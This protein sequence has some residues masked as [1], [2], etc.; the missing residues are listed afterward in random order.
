MA[1]T[2]GYSFGTFERVTPLKLHQ[3]VDNAVLTQIVVDG[4]YGILAA[5][6]A[7]LLVGKLYHGRENLGSES[8]TYS[9]VCTVSKLFIHDPLFDGS[10]VLASPD[11]METARFVSG[12]DFGAGGKVA[13]SICMLESTNS[14]AT[15]ELGDQAG[16]AL[17]GPNAVL[18]CVG[19]VTLAQNK[20]GRVIIKGQCPP[21]TNGTGGNSSPWPCRM[22]HGTIGTSTWAQTTN[23]VGII[24][25]DVDGCFLTRLDNRSM[26]LDSRTIG[27][28]H[29][30]P[31]QV[32][33]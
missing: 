18:G 12:A 10:V 33:N 26:P 24:G 22:Y 28:Y 21:E 30:G 7:S 13:G 1:I 5:T 31:I 19:A 2:R 23:L 4:A 15:I 14:A 6:P 3:L 8:S 17:N 9:G 32:A 16:N 29:G 20:A 25:S 11:V 27:Y